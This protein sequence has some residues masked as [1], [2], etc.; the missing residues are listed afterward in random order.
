MP[1]YAA[2]EIKRAS[3]IPGAELLSIASGQPHAAFRQFV[4]LA[5]ARLSRVE[6]AISPSEAG[7]NERV[8]PLLAYQVAVEHG[9]ASELL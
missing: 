9:A 5:A 3:S 2:C 6:L 7:R 1:S 8:T 4:L